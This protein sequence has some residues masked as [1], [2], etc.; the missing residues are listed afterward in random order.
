[1]LL[2]GGMC[3]LPLT[4]EGQRS[5]WASEWA[6]IGEPLEP[7]VRDIFPGNEFTFARI[8]YTFNGR[9]GRGGFG[10]GGGFGA[11]EDQMLGPIRRGFWATDYPTADEN[12]SLRLSQVT[13]LNVSKTEDG[14]FKHVV[15]R[16]DENALFEYPF[17]YTCNVGFM[18]LTEP[19]QEGLR[20][21]LLRG[22]FLM[23]DDFWGDG[24][25]DNLE[26]QMGMVLSP[27]E[28]PLVKIPL[29]HPIFHIVF[30]LKEI[31]QV[32][33][34][35]VFY[36]SGGTKDISYWPPRRSY[37]YW[38]YDANIWGIFD[39]EGRLM[40][41]AMHN[42]DTGDGWEREGQNVEYFKAFSAPMA[43]PLGINIVVYAMLH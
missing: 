12:F 35:G 20:A 8:Q 3:L 38:G 9:R 31:P 25:R 34:M 4:I 27:E 10:T 15:V 28:Y 1:M 42:S 19:E 39:K 17:I 5:E 11:L 7:M 13:T 14:K 37:D 30:D 16:L 21:Y 26:Y 43:Y 24:P 2:L 29:D 36:A 6:T 18:N 33:D 22:G 40:L 41:I 32:P 23:I